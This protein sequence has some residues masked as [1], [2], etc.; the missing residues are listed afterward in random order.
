[1]DITA[2]IGLLAGLAAMIGGFFLGRR[3]SLRIAAA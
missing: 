2:I 1:M 3:Q